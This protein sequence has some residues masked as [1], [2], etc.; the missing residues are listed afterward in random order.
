MG[1]DFLA[2]GQKPGVSTQ[3]FYKGTDFCF[4]GLL[5]LDAD[6]AL[7]CGKEVVCVDG[8]ESCID[9]VHARRAE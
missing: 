4:S 2:L 1:F 6:V 5:Q 8:I 7:L 3:H 9:T